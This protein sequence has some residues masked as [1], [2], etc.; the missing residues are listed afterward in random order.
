M[1]GTSLLDTVRLG[2]TGGNGVFW[3]LE[4]T[5]TNDFTLEYG[6]E[7]MRVTAGGNVGIGVPNPIAKLHVGGT[8]GTDG[9]MFPDGT[10]QTTATLIGPAGADGA[11]GP[12]GPQGIAG[13]DG[14][15][16]PKGDKGDTGAQG[17]PG[18]QGVKGDKGDPGDS[19]WLL[20]GVNTYYNDGNV[21]L[22]TA[23]P[24]ARLHVYDGNLIVTGDSGPRNFQLQI[25]GG[26]TT[27]LEGWLDRGIIG[28]LTD[29]R[30]DFVVN[31]SQKMTILPSGFVGIGK[32]DP[33]YN[34]DVK[35]TIRGDNVSPSDVRL[36]EDIHTIDN[37]L[38]KVENI[39]GVN[40]RWIDKS[41]GEGRQIGVIAQEVE[42]VIPEAV[43][44]DK[45][46]MKS[47]S[48]GKLVGILIEAVKELNEENVLLKQEIKKIK[49]TVGL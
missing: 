16:G 23:S 38:E 36:K 31:N 27:Y 10:L 37:A 33:S 21:G 7:M 44:R 5:D 17:I 47:V 34:L 11:Q 22:G 1:K 48:Y 43:S 46:G 9:I 41:M 15:Q 3:D 4:E 2:D 42:S 12:V 28:T 18:V 35:G 13:A 14:A 8:P 45:E 40:F 19:H 32:T 6:A 24:D 39:R 26:A 25:T 49:E 20:D 29:H 30:L